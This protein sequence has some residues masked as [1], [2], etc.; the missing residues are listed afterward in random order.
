M[1][2]NILRSL[3]PYQYVVIAIC[4]LCNML[5]GMDVLIISYAAP[6]IAKAWSLSPQE[7]GVIFSSGLIGMSVGAVFIAPFADKLGRKLMMLLAPFIMGVSIFLTSYASSINQL[8]I[9]R[10]LSGIGIG[11]M[12]ATTASIAAEYSPK[13]S[14]GFWVSFVVA[15]YPVVTGLVSVSIISNYGWEYLFKIAGIVSFV[16]IP[17]ITV[18]LKEPKIE[19]TAS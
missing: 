11:I 9:L 17:I 5:D 6:A 3:T 12:M 15:G 14:R 2:N 19:K 4:F 10:F 13:E 1:N 16:V 7:L 8:M 18:Y